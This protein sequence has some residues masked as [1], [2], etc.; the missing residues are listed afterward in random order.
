MNREIQRRVNLA[1]DH[2]IVLKHHSGSQR[3]KGLSAS[4]ALWAVSAFLKLLL[5]LAS[6]PQ[7]LMRK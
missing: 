5:R 7:V 4:K 2:T 6:D 3:S 1:N